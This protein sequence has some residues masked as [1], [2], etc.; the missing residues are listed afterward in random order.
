MDDNMTHLYFDIKS[1][2]WPIIYSPK[3]NVNLFGIEVYLF[4]DT[5]KWKRIYQ[6]SKN[7]GDK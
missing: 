5:K 6:V 1:H 2:Q 3:Y 7:V 4:L